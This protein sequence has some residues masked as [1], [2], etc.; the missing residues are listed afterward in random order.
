LV[1]L[2]ILFPS[3]QEP[4]RLLQERARFSGAGFVEGLVDFRDDME[5]VENMQG[6]GTFVTFK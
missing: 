2:Q 5:T 3:E 1:G 6:L 4:A